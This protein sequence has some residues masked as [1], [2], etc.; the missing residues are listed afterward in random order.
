MGFDAPAER[1]A[2]PAALLYAPVADEHGARFLEGALTCT[3]AWRGKR[4]R[5]PGDHHISAVPVRPY[6]DFASV[7]VTNSRLC[8][9]PL[10]AEAS[11]ACC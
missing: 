6:R 9:P 4:T 11:D 3:S 7:V 1:E 8:L 5:V 2:L 10:V